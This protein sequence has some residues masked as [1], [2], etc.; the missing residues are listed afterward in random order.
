MTNL[1][2]SSASAPRT[3]I[4]SFKATKKIAGLVAYGLTFTGL[5]LVM[6]SVLGSEVWEWPVWVTGFVRDVGLLLAAVMAGTILHERLIRDETLSIVVT[7][8]DRKLSEQ[9][10]K[11][12]DIARLGAEEVH[13]IFTE[14][15]PRMKGIRF[16]H[17]RR[18]NYSAYYSWVNEQN[19]QDLFFAGRS[20]LHRIDA[21]IKTRAAGASAEEVILRKLKEGSRISIA[22]LDP[23]IDI[24]DRL[25][26]EEGQKP[27]AMLGDI[28]TS[29]EICRRLFRLLQEN[30]AD[31][32]PGSFLAIRVFDRVPYFAY[33][34]QDEQM[35]IGFY[36]SSDRGDT[37]AAYELV[38]T[39]TQRIFG[40]HFARIMS[41]A[42]QNTLVEFDGAR[43]RPSFDN[44]LFE[45]LYIHFC[46]PHVLGQQRTDELLGRPLLHTVPA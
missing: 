23:R 16:L 12:T 30:Y 35:I 32:Q 45:E 18:R 46:Q 41:Q 17:D 39:E 29:I 7:E 6:L 2:D 10:P 22:F 11:T 8:L 26:R 31:L 36:F 38:D 20:V 19:P 42:A 28:A 21:D 14:R 33:H 15:P 5:S 27:E 13:R 43:G 34:K 24:L 9:I 4:P 25:A 3:D 37:S 44:R 40:E 1:P